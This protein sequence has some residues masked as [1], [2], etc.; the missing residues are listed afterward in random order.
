M[1]GASEVY[2]GL[3]STLG[4]RLATLAQ[5]S[6]DLEL[7]LGYLSA[8]LSNRAGPQSLFLLLRR[9]SPFIDGTH[10]DS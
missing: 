1:K 3:K 10:D 6:L 2:G 9:S 8:A 4:C 7:N 5:K